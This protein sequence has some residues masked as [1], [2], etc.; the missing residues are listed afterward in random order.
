MKTQRDGM[1]NNRYYP[2]VVVL[3]PT[4]ELVQQASS[5][6]GHTSKHGTA[7]DI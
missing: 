7:M 4:R 6:N 3:Q 2:S 5:S 1:P